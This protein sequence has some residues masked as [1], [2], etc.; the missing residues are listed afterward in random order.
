MNFWNWY[1]GDYVDGNETEPRE[2]TLSEFI[3]M[4][5]TR[6]QKMSLN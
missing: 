4:I 1:N 5:K 6:Y 3:E 2:I